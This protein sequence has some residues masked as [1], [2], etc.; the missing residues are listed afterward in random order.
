MVNSLEELHST[1]VA[2]DSVRVR[3]EELLACYENELPAETEAGAEQFIDLPYV[4]Q[5]QPSSSDTTETSRAESPSR[6]FTASEIVLAFGRQVAW[7]SLERQW[8]RF[9]EGKPI[10][11]TPLLTEADAA[12]AVRTATLM[13][14]GRIR[15]ERIGQIPLYLVLGPNEQPKA[16]LYDQQYGIEQG[17]AAE[18][19]LLS[20]IEEL[21][22]AKEFVLWSEQDL[23]AAIND[24]YSGWRSYNPKQHTINI[25][26]LDR[27]ALLVAVQNAMY[28]RLEAIGELPE[29]AQCIDE[30]EA[31]TL[32]ANATSEGLA[33]IE[34]A[35]G[36]PASWLPL[37]ATTIKMHAKSS[38]DMIA[39][40][41]G[42]LQVAVE[43]MLAM[44]QPAR[45]AAA[46]SLPYADLQSSGQ[47][48]HERSVT[49]VSVP[50]EDHNQYAMQPAPDTPRF[51]VSEDEEPTYDEVALQKPSHRTRQ[52]LEQIQLAMD[53]SEG[54]GPWCVMF[55]WSRPRLYMTY[56]LQRLLK[57]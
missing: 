11:T 19:R 42:L 38:P 54:P 21:P 48:H 16:R 43:E 37:K 45:F 6:A 52:Q 30:A 10:G 36:L 1:Q 26:G 49:V 24:L 23:R 51:L 28:T 7:Q 13:G 32:I 55:F 27:V 31:A 20:P 25:K 12:E 3:P 15:V 47:G 56:G 44:E 14:S 57:Q 9:A 8:Q 5:G 39:Q 2:P 40:S 41:P 33:T 46:H 34:A 53:I 17:L 35:G 22:A 18:Q 29:D 50:T 4:N